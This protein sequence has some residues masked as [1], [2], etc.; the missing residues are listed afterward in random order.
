MEA[1]NPM[2]AQ[3]YDESTV[4]GL[5]KGSIDTHIHSGPDVIPRKVDDLSLAKEAA[6]AGMRGLIIKCHVSPTE[7][8]AYLVQKIVPEVKIFG[9]IALNSS[10]GGLNPEAVQLSVRMGAKIVWMPTTSALTH[11][12][13]LALSDFLKSMGGGIK[14]KGITI[15]NEDGKLKEEVY[16]I[17]KIVKESRIILATGHLS[18]KESIALIDEALRHSI[19]KIL[20]TH[21]EAHINLFTMEEQKRLAAKGV[22]FERCWSMT[23][24]I[25][26]E[27]ARLSPEVLAIAI[28]TVGAAT[29]VMATD[30]GQIVNPTPPEGM[31]E[32][33]AAMLRLGITPKEIELMV[34]FNPAQLLDI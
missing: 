9:G 27:K 2:D 33:I 29:T 23:T 14:E 5:V 24:K 25:G 30:L 11:V 28:K 7:G 6:M 4:T 16:E 34:K 3:G 21:P 31:R 13:N 18:P 32:Y 19:Q 20:V 17:L 10:V 12:Q 8:R 15:F 1:A 26:G 22:Y